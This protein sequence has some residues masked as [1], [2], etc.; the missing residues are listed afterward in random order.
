MSPAQQP[1]HPAGTGL[2]AYA[3]LMPFMSA[4]APTQWTPLPLIFIALAAPWIILNAKRPHL[5]ELL[6][7][8]AGFLLAWAIG[9]LAIFKSPL[10]PG[11]KNANY[12]LAFLVS[13]AAFLVFIRAWVVGTRIDWDIVVRA[14]NASLTFL[15][16]AVILEFFTASFLG[17]FFSDVI[18]YAHDK[19]EVGNLFV[20][21]LRRPRAFSAEP[22]FTALAFESLWPLTWMASR[23]NWRRQALYLLGF[24][25]LASAAA[26]VSLAFASLFVWVVRGRSVKPLMKVLVIIAPV[27]LLIAATDLGREAFWSALGRKFDVV[28]LEEAAGNDAVTVLD[29]LSAYSTGL[30]LFINQPAGIGWGTLGEAFASGGSLPDVGTVTG[31]GMLSLYV[32]VAVASGW[33]GLVLFAWFIWNRVFR[34]VRC[35]HELA[36]LVTISLAAVATHHALI[37]EWQFPFLWFS[38]ALAD[39]LLLDRNCTAGHMEGPFIALG[40]G[41]AG[42]AD[43]GADSV[44]YVKQDAAR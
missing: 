32:D 25:L 18:P 40:A 2:I 5:L 10:G 9:C 12:A 26:V 38:L 22:G 39:K 30:S 11:T 29:R 33:A 13:Y 21:G 41:A 24:M 19:L 8:D 4:L 14:A 36:P 44:R 23:R 28:G 16:C 1:V 35:A 34:V 6:R 31:S 3:I 37:T 42:T 27:A 17:V 7:L 20:E 15:S 43:N